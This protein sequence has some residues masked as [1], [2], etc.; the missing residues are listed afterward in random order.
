MPACSP[1]GLHL[2]QS[3]VLARPAPCCTRHGGVGRSRVRAGG[4]PGAGRQGQHGSGGQGRPGAGRGRYGGPAGRVRD[5]SIFSRAAA[6]LPRAV[7]P[8]WAALRAPR[9]PPTPATRRS[10]RVLC[11]TRLFCKKTRSLHECISLS[12][13]LQ[14][15]GLSGPAGDADGPVLPGGRRPGAPAGGARARAR[16]AATALSSGAPPSAPPLT[17]AAAPRPAQ[18]PRL[19]GGDAAGGVPGQEG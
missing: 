13:L 12:P 10:S 1:P 5:V 9:A 3:L 18:V 19:R 15:P 8:T 2:T 17:A 14:V 6:P 4:Q 11:F 16:R 7:N